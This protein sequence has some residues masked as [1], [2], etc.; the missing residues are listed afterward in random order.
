MKYMVPYTVLLSHLLGELT[1]TQAFSVIPKLL[2]VVS[3]DEAWYRSRYPD[4]AKA[5]DAGE[6]RSARDHFI[7]AGYMEGRLPFEHELDE[8]WYLNTYPDIVSELGSGDIQTARQHY[9]EHGYQEGRLPGRIESAPPPPPWWPYRADPPQRYTENFHRYARRGGLVRP[10]ENVN[11]FVHDNDGNRGDMARFFFFCLMFDQIIKD[12]L[13]GDI[14]ELGVWKGNTASILCNISRSLTRTLYLFDTFAGFHI[15]DLEGIDAGKPEKQFNDTSLDSVQS[16]IGTD[17]VCYVP[18]HF[19][20]SAAQICDKIS[21]CL[22]HIDCDLHNPIKAGLEY[23]YPR[24]IPGGF[25]IVHDY[26]S[27]HWDGA[28]KAVDEFLMD[29][30][31]YA[32]PLPD[33]SGS[34]VIRRSKLP[35][36]EEAPPCGGET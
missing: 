14:A 22:V 6:T 21:Y 30:P 25:L 7:T 16:F 13:Q 3:V 17:S 15:S 24:L 23:F 19:P 18:G 36:K 1:E 2:Q 9:D 8:E 33:T 20:E 5:I 4:V 10:Y 34:V 27:L 35:H 26:S 29:K 12:D 32:I 11:G 31:E 28:E